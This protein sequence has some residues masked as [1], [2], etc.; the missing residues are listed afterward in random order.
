MALYQVFVFDCFATSLI[1]SE[2]C[3]NLHYPT[4]AGSREVK[5]MGIRDDTSIEDD[6]GV[7]GSRDD[8]SSGVRDKM[9]NKDVTS[10]RDGKTGGV[11]DYMAEARSEESDMH[12]T[13]H[14][15]NLYTPNSYTPYTPMEVGVDEPPT[16]H[17]S[18]SPVL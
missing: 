17:R 4:G 14:D 1:V 2:I 5:D 12:L 9:V 10:I 16:F 11:S 8:T 18:F 6:V 13:G 15:T 3:A 7:R